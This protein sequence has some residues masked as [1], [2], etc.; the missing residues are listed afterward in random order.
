MTGSAPNPESITTIGSKIA[1][2][3]AMDSR[4]RP[5]VGSG[6]TPRAF[7]PVT[8]C[9]SLTE[10][11]PSLHDRWIYAAAPW[12]REFCGPLPAHP[13]QPR[14]ISSFCPSARSFAPR[15]LHAVLAVRRSVVRFARCDQ[16]TRGLSPPGRCPCRAHTKTA[17]ASARAVLR[18][19]VLELTDQPLRI[20]GGAYAGAACSGA[21]IQRMPSLK[22]C[23]SRLLKV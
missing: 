17:R 12:S 7:V 5:S 3:A 13:A 9:R 8:T 19:S 21:N 15:F 1:R 20:S 6:M 22:S 23:E 14:L 10:H 11:R 16:L 2:P 18:S 4:L